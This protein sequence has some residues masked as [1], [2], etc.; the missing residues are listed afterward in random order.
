[1]IPQATFL[2][3][4]I[5]RGD[6]PRELASGRVTYFILRAYT[7]TGDSHAGRVVLEVV[8]GEAA[9]GAEMHVSADNVNCVFLFFFSFSFFHSIIIIFNSCALLFTQENFYR[10]SSFLCNT[11]TVNSC[12]T[13]FTQ[14]NFY[15]ISSFLCN[16]STVNRCAHSQPFITI[17]SKEPI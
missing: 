14:E 12:A 1:M 6:S 11:S 5:F 2:S 17:L 9:L 3:L 16:T 4:F 15:R 8:M 13:L 10:I 7:G